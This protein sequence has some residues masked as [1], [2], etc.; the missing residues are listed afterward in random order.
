MY[1]R[2]SDECL[3][4]R[5]YSCSGCLISINRYASSANSFVST[6]GLFSLNTAVAFTRFF[7]KGML[8]NFSEEIPSGIHKQNRFSLYRNSLAP[9]SSLIYSCAKGSRFINSRHSSAAIIKLPPSTGL[10]PYTIDGTS[11]K[12]LVRLS[13]KMSSASIRYPLICFASIVGAFS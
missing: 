5:I 12:G 8:S 6:F 11:P 3:G 2:F 9:T 10:F 1:L 4:T 7:T 13:M